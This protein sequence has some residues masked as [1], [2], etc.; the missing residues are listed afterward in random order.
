M[1]SRPPD[2]RVSVPVMDA[3][4]SRPSE[5]VTVCIERWFYEQLLG[6]ASEIFKDVFWFGTPA[7]IEAATINSRN[8]LN[9]MLEPC[10]VPMTIEF[11]LN[12]CD[13]EWR[14]S[15]GDP[16]TN[17]GNV[18]GADGAQGA[19]GVQGIQGIQGVQGETGQQGLPGTSDVIQFLPLDPSK[20]DIERRCASAVN[21]SEWIFDRWNDQLDIVEA[22][23]DAISAM[24]GI[25]AVMPVAYVIVD[26]VF[27]AI[28]EFFE[29]GINVCRAWDT[30]AQREEFAADMYCLIA[31]DGNLTTDEWEA[32]IDT[33]PSPCIINPPECAFQDYLRTLEPEAVVSR[34]RLSGYGDL[35]LV[36]GT[37]DCTWTVTFLGGDGL[38][39]DLDTIIWGTY[40]S[41]NDRI[42][43]VY[44]NVASNDQ[45]KEATIR[46]DFPEVTNITAISFQFNV[47]PDATV[48]IQYGV[49]I[50]N[51]FGNTI[52]EQDLYDS[53][54]SGTISWTGS[55]NTLQIAMQATTNADGGT[56][57]HSYIQQ[58]TITGTGSNPFA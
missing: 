58:I 18:C 52:L 55:I 28:N 1:T 12:G 45:R 33:F 38:D 29:A 21:F 31:D 35:S 54:A 23:N 13:L 8:Q 5:L 19:Q 2:E 48:P 43:G 50:W 36:C 6:Y 27:D 7:E 20:S 34:M 53:S 10:G 24:D 22:T 3:S 47:A 56:S 57:G 25:I 15:S 39:T 11:Q 37:F 44:R 17:L 4:I 26:Q 16:W 40:D 32:Y 9:A 51:V 42:D 41:V 46:F 30:V 14:L 49:Q